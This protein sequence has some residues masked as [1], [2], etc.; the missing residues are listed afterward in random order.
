MSAA[1]PPPPAVVSDRGDHHEFHEDG[2]DDEDDGLAYADDVHH[3]DAAS[4]SERDAAGAAAAPSEPEDGRAIHPQ[5]QHPNA[6]T[7]G[8]PPEA[9]ALH[10]R[11]LLAFYSVHAPAKAQPTGIDAS[12]ELFGPRIWAELEAKYGGRT[13]GFAPPPDP[14]AAAAA[15]AAASDASNDHDDEYD[16]GTLDF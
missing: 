1:A 7:W 2:D 10:K 9:V 12:W 5:P 8:L 11:R 4:T 16:D 6:N 14:A 15:T 3:G 13:I